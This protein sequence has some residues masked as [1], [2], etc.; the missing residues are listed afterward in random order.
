VNSSFNATLT[1]TEF[2]NEKYPGTRP[3][4]IL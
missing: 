1:I 2:T 4:A 3:A